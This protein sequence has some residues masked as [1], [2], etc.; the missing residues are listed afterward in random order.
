MSS[1]VVILYDHIDKIEMNDAKRKEIR[2][3]KEAL[4]GNNGAPWLWEAW[5]RSLDGLNS[6]EL[7]EVIADVSPLAGHNPL[8]GL[9]EIAQSKLQAQLTLEHVAAQEKMSKAADK[10]WWAGT[11]LA[12]A[13]AF[14]T[15]VGL[16]I[17]LL[18]LKH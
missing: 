11:W 9:L 16:Y 8:R 14:M 10:L 3:A 6:I 12:V 5:V 13:A 18:E 17:A 4:F 7:L 15:L 2:Q 1:C